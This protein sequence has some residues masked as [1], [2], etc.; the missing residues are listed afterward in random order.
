MTI[1]S[2]SSTMAIGPPSAASGATWPIIRPWVPPEN[3]PSVSSATESPRPSPTSAPVT[4][5]I[6]CMPGPADRALVADDDDVAGLDLLGA[7]RVVAG[8]LRVE[9]AGRSAVLAALVAGELDHAAVG[10]QRAVQDRQAAGRLERRLERDD[11]L[12]AGR[13]DGVRRDLGDRPAVD[14]RRVAV[15]EPGPLEQLAHDQGDAAGLVHVGRGVAA[16]R[17]H[18]GDD[19]RPVGDGAELVDVERDAELVGDR[20]QV[21]DAVGRAAGR[22]DAGDPVLE[23]L[24]G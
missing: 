12:L 10:R 23:R 14:G 20:Q 17:L 4:C 13:L 24:R 19:R 21:E 7:D 2:P 5:S 22:G 8:R 16:A 1:V 15:E 9:D 11:D 18:V 6:S 3:R